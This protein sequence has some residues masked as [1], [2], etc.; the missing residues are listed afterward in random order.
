MAQRYQMVIYLGTEPFATFHSD[1][2]F[3]AIHHGDLI[4]PPANSGKLL[5][6]ASIEHNY[7]TADELREQ[8]HVYTTE[9]PKR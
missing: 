8:L 4:H 9:E 2:P 3:L 7:L 5:R 6:V 1:Q